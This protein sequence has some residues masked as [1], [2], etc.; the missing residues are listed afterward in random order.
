[1]P[2]S[3]DRIRINKLQREAEGYLELGLPALALDTLRRLGDPAHF[4]PSTLYL[5]GE[6]LRAAERY[7]EAIPAL[8]QAAQ[9]ESE[10]VHVW[11]ALG[12]CYKRTGRLDQAVAAIRKALTAD[13]TEALLH[14]NLACYLSLAGDKEKALDHLAQALNL[15]PEYRNLIDGES[16][17]DPIRSDPDFQALLGLIV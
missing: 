8:E 3:K 10:N 14:Y 17:F 12:W 13:P 6:A 5:W 1:M 4:A 7:S 16:D 15:D 11:L 2:Q 9:V